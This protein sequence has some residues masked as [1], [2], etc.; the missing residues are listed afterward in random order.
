MHTRDVA[1]TL[2]TLFSE[3]VNGAGASGAYALN[4]GDEGL[5]RS[6]AEGNR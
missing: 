2:A 5:L 4:P 3:L 6:L 1:S